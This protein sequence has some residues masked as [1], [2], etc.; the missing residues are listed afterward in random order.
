MAG[1]G[2]WLEN[3]SRWRMVGAGE[4]WSLEN[5]RRWRNVVARAIYLSCPTRE[6]D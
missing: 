2:R 3:G 5:G 6:I 4:W 1:A